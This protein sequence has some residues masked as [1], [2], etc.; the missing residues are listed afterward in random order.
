MV[1]GTAED[2]TSKEETEQFIFEETEQRF[3]LEA[4][5]TIETT[6][7]MKQLGYLAKSDIAEQILNGTFIISSDLD[8]ATA[9][10]LE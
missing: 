10:V 1:I 3:Q 7:L 5:A 6:K 8:D 4:N 2:L 9:L